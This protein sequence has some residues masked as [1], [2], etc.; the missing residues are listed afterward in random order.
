[1]IITQGDIQHERITKKMENSG[2][3]SDKGWTQEISEGPGSNP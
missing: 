3:Q 1:M 2:I